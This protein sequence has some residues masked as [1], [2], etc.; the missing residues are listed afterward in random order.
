MELGKA[1]KLEAEVIT[2]HVTWNKLYYTT[3][4]LAFTCKTKAA[5]IHS[6]LIGIVQKL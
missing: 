1:S 4:P 3:V 6:T 5:N 2:Q